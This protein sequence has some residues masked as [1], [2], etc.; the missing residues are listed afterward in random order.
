MKMV[1]QRGKHV[2][3]SFTWV[4]FL[5]TNEDIWLSLCSSP[6]RLTRTSPGNYTGQ[7]FSVK[8]QI[9]QVSHES[10]GG[11]G[12]LEI[13]ADAR[14]PW[15]FLGKTY[16]VATHTYCAIDKQRT[17]LD[18]NLMV[19]LTGVMALYV[20]FKRNRVDDFLNQL[21]D[22]IQKAATMLESRDPLLATQLGADQ[23]K[24][25]EDWREALL[26]DPGPEPRREE[27]LEG[28]V[29][30]SLAQNIMMIKAEAL[31]PDKH[32]ITAQRQLPFGDDH[33]ADLRAQARELAQINN[34]AMVTRGGRSFTGRNVEFRQVAFEFGHKLYRDCLGGEL[35]SVIPLLLHHRHQAM[36]R[37]E[38]NA[39]VEEL[40]WEAMHDGEDFLA[41][42]VQFSRTLGGVGVT[43][44]IEECGRSGGILLVGAD[45]RGDLPGVETEV[46][47]VGSILSSA[48]VP[49][50]EVLTRA[51]ASRQRVIELLNSG[52]FHVFHYSGHSV[53]DAAYPYQSYLELAQGT[54]LFLHELTYLT[55]PQPDGC[56][57]KLVFLNS[58]ESGRVGQDETTGRNLSL[59]RV[60]REAGVGYVIGMAWN[61][62]DDAATQVGS[63]F[64]RLLMTGPRLNPI[65]AMRETRR[66]VAID[67]S[68]ADGSWLAPVLYT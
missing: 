22:Y 65:A 8:L 17:S 2:N 66:K 3:A 43:S 56:A 18:L 32:L 6:L 7:I 55:R 31:M 37:L 47:S 49:R 26:P 45:A 52:D 9:R 35:A 54:R 12:H 23:L 20:W 57:L 15:G 30:I 19:E 58:C 42:K 33:C 67:R 68:W 5:L 46:Q 50:V 29:R 48:G 39:A 53:F 61:V 34:P 40:P 16:T 44:G 13:L 51:Q 1:I 10:A 38:V 28:A 24:R 21:C 59:C 63:V 27:L 25:V 64:Y 41:L 11:R 62:A 60:L 14:M 36:M 4:D